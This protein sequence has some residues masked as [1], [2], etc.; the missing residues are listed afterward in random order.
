MGLVSSEVAVICIVDD[1]D[2]ARSGL[3][4]L[5]LSLGYEARSFA[6][7]EQLL[8]SGALLQATCVVTDLHMPGLSGLD[9]QSRLRSAGYSIPVIF[10]TAYPSEAHRSRAI[11]RGALG[12]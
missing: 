1:D 6:S 7:A 3:E 10:V 9:L 2:W 5:V 8:E 11:E 4:D 12:C